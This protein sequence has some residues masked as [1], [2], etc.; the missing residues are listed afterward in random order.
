M[1]DSPTATRTRKTVERPSAR[2]RPGWA[3]PTSHARHKHH[4]RPIASSGDDGIVVACARTLCRPAQDGWVSA[5]GTSRQKSRQPPEKCP[6]TATSPKSQRFNASARGVF[7][8]R[9]I[10]GSSHTPA[11]GISSQGMTRP[12]HGPCIMENRNRALCRTGHIAEADSDL[13]RRLDRKGRAGVVASDP[14]PS[15]HLSGRMRRMSRGSGLRREQRRDG[16]GP[17]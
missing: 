1:K 8:H 14:R 10:P 3:Q 15:R 12:T 6:S 5:W 9:V 4:G 16:Y 2:S 11:Q 7:T 17:G 13:H